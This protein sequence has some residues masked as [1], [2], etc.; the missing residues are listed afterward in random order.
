MPALNE[1]SE[2]PKDPKRDAVDFRGLGMTG[3]CD[4][5]SMGRLRRELVMH[6]RR[7]KTYD[8]GEAALV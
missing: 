7:D 3:Q 5:D 1:R 6:K 2:S 4:V 8:C